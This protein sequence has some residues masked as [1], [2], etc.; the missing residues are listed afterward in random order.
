MVTREIVPSAILYGIKPKIYSIW[1]ALSMDLP[2]IF[3]GKYAYFISL[4]YI[5]ECFYFRNF[6][7][8]FLNESRPNIKF[9]LR[10]AT[11]SVSTISSWVVFEVR[12]SRNKN[13]LKGSNILHL[14][15]I[16]CNQPF[17]FNGSWMGVVHTVYQCTKILWNTNLPYGDQNLVTKC[18]FPIIFFL[19][20][21]YR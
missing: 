20:D 10:W 2:Y 7:I 21:F 1:Q 16:K 9:L 13:T 14:I 3:L 4:F 17:K 19:R 5:C 15:H 18:L 8:I 12:I 6:E 11:S